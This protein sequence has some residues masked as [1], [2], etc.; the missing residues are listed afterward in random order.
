MNKTVWTGVIVAVIFGGGGFYAGMQYQAGQTT[1]STAGASAYAGRTGGA[2]RT[3]FAG[4]GGGATFG[5]IIAMDPTSI[6]VQLPTS[7]ST[8]A[9]SGTKIILYDTSTQINQM[10]TVPASKLSVGQSVTVAGTANTD[11]S[12]T[13]TSIQIRPA[14]QRAAGTG[15]TSQ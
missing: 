9:T 10:Q 11:G 2:G 6:T 4:A 12:I 13:A 7:T 14:T 8:L 1:G 3:G 5:T 15:T